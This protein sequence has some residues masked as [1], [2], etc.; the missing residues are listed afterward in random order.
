MDNNDFKDFESRVHAR[1]STIEGKIERISAKVDSLPSFQAVLT[2]VTATLSIILGLFWFPFS[3]FISQGTANIERRLDGLEGDILSLATNL[4]DVRVN[5]DVITKLGDLSN[6]QLK[7]IADGI[8]VS[9]GA[10]DIGINLQR[11]DKTLAD[12]LEEDTSEF[13][14]FN[15]LYR[16]RPGP[17]PT[18]ATV[19][20]PND[21]AL[22][23]L[24]DEI[25]ERLSSGGAG[26][27]K[28]AFWGNHIVDEILPIGKV[29]STASSSPSASILLTSNAV[30]VTDTTREVP[31]YEVVTTVERYIRTQD[32]LIVV[33]NEILP[34]EGIPF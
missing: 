24:P 31:L 25:V 19:F 21:R 4:N 17:R 32:G 8:S 26:L 22:S 30:L 29:S 1:I 13:G 33:I 18:N 11:I 28:D 27:I 6:E 16:F 2:I 3:G 34:T 23:S 9:E 10:K 15:V 20:I 7:V 12:T 14:V 5:V